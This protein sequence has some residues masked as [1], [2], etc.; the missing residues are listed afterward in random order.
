MCKPLEIKSQEAF[1]CYLRDPAN[2]AN[3]PRFAAALDIPSPTVSEPSV[4]D[5]LSLPNPPIRELAGPDS[6]W[7]GLR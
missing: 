4:P 7:K 2:E 6:N 3:F 1:S 5:D